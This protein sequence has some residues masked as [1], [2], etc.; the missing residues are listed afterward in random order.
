MEKKAKILILGTYPFGN[1]GEHLIKTQCE[2]MT[3]EKK[4]KEIKVVIEKLMHFKP[5]KIAVEANR[6]KMRN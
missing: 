2:D 3:T 5:N 1:G 6:G 4:Q